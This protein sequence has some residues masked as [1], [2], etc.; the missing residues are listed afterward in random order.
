MESND[1][2]IQSFAPRDVDAFRALNEQWIKEV[3]VLEHEDELVLND[4]EEH[5]LRYGGEIFMARMHGIPVGC[6]AL[7]L[8]AANLMELAKMAVAREYQG[9]GI[10]RKLL[11]HAIDRARTRGISAIVLGS[12][13]RLK[14]ALHLYETSGFHYLKGDE[15]PSLPYARANVFMRLDLYQ[16]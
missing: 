16:G 15:A 11:H 1:L 9:R 6:C 14:E 13:T 8:K 12:N 3:F 5:I 10:G 2:M 4:P 7:I